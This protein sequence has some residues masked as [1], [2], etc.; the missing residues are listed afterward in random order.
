M[1]GEY[2]KEL[3]TAIVFLLP[4]L[5]LVWKGAKMAARIEHLEL[6]F[7]DKSDRFYKNVTLLEDKVE[8]ERLAT[9]SS[10]ATIMATLTDI[11]KT[12]VRVETQLEIEEGKK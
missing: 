6:E 1:T 3:I 2:I 9:D 10:I 8:Q 4:V 11:Q 5:T 7:K 12:L